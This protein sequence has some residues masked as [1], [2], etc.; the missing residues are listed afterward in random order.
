M[1]R[2][3]SGLQTTFKN[4]SVAFSTELF[5]SKSNRIQLKSV[6]IFMMPYG[7]LY[8]AVFDDPTSIEE[9]SER[10]IELYYLY[11]RF[12]NALITYGPLVGPL[13]LTKSHL[14]FKTVL[15]KKSGK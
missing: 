7:E 4:P 10:R 11:K 9:L 14:C 6:E 13:Q 5:Q 1:R 12:K 2:R 8:E 15:L 3:S